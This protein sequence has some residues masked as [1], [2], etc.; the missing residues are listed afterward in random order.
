MIATALLVSHSH[1]SVSCRGHWVTVGPS[2]PLQYIQQLLD[3]EGM[4]SV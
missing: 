2:P 1:T 3:F 4:Y